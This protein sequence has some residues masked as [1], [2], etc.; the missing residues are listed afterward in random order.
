MKYGLLC[1]QLLRNRHFSMHESFDFLEYFKHN[2]LKYHT[3]VLNNKTIR[4]GYLKA[5]KQSN[6][7]LVFYIKFYKEI[8]QNGNNSCGG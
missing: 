4:E 2:M 1:M 3:F 7:S 8:S 5:Y 6:Y